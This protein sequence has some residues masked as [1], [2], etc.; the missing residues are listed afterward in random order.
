LDTEPDVESSGFDA[1]FSPDA[2]NMRAPDIAVGH[3]LDRP[4]VFP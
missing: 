1:D 3:V 4:G 2:K